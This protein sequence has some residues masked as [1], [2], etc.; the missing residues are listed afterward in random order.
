MPP[1][2]PDRLCINPDLLAVYRPDGAVCRAWEDNSSHEMPE[3]LRLF[4]GG[5]STDHARSRNPK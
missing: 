5:Y 3:S 2:F 4:A 1:S